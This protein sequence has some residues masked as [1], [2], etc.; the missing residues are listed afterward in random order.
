MKFSIFITGFRNLVWVAFIFGWAGAQNNLDSSQT[1]QIL[2]LDSATTSYG[3][4]KIS[5]SKTDSCLIH[6]KESVLE[7]GLPAP[8]HFSTEPTKADQ[9]AKQENYPDLHNSVGMSIIS[10]NPGSVCE[11]LAKALLVYPNKLVVKQ[12]IFNHRLNCNNWIDN[13]MLWIMTHE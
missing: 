6:Y 13:K 3:E 1:Q 10:H 11:I 8:C 12:K 5:R 2:F 4:V 9:S 7:T